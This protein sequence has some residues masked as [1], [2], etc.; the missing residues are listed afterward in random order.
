M[1]PEDAVRLRHLV[2][3]AETDRMLAEAGL[4]IPGPDEIL[5]RLRSTAMIDPCPAMRTRPA[6]SSPPAAAP[7]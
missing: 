5:A 3:A 1:P 7:G 2:D 6:S 4:Y